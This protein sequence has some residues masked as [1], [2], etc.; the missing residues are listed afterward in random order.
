MAS[1]TRPAAWTEAEQ[2]QLETLARRYP[3]S[4]HSLVT[5]CA[6]IAAGLPRKSIRDVGARLRL[7]ALDPPRR[8][9]PRGRARRA[10]LPREPA[11]T[12][13]NKMW[14]SSARCAKF[15]QNTTDGQHPAHAPLRRERPRPSRRRALESEARSPF[16]LEVARCPR[17]AAGSARRRSRDGIR[18]K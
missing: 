8:R 7:L 15:A 5:Q 9:S 2:K 17:A 10:T 1:L 4:E 3:S 11:A 16:P 14:P 13:S 12:S 18:S 6:K